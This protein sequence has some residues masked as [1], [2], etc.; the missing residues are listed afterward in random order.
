M[1]EQLGNI[2]PRTRLLPFRNRRTGAGSRALDHVVVL[3]AFSMAQS[4][5]R[6]GWCVMVCLFI[7]CSVTHRQ[8]AKAAL[9]NERFERNP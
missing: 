9:A 1:Y 8:H 7:E 3:G 4:I 2:M 6:C 5:L